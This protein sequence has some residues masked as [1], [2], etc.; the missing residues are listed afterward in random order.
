MDAPSPMPWWFR[1]WT[2]SAPRRAY[3]LWGLVLALVVFNVDRGPAVRLFT[4]GQT[5]DPWGRFFHAEL[6]RYGFQWLPGN[7]ASAP[8]SVWA[9]GI[10]LWLGTYLSGARL[11]NAGMSSRWALLFLVPG[12]RPLL[13]TILVVI[14]PRGDAAA[15]ESDSTPSS[16]GSRQAWLHRWMPSSHWG[17]ALSCSTAAAE[18]GVALVQVNTELLGIYGWTL[19]LATPYLLGFLA[20]WM[21]SLHRPLRKGDAVQI[22]F[23]TVISSGVLL[24]GLAIEG[25]ICLVMAAPIAVGLSWLGAATAAALMTRIRRR[26]E[27]RVMCVAVAIIPML[28]LIERGRPAPPPVYSFSSE[29]FIAA[30]ARRIWPRI[31][32]VAGLPPD[33]NFW[34]R[35]NLATFR[36]ARTE[37][38]GLGAV[39]VCEFDTGTARE[40]VTDW[41]PPFLLGLRVET[42][43]TP[44]QEWTFY[45]H[46]HPRHLE[47]YYQ[48]N[49]AAFELTPVEGGTLV[50]GTTEFQHGLWPADYW[51]WWCRP[52]IHGL[53]RRVLN[54]VKDRTE[55]AMG[56]GPQS[57]VP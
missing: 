7:D 41:E 17:C 28:C 57:R 30:P 23:L 40:I 53:Q 44:L 11:R 4:L 15:E 32:D 18:L 55:A 38:H 45:R 33:Q 25:V 43:P 51:A 26:S 9:G 2:W 19:F 47:G 34:S 52:V 8:A 42:T 27:G 16:A 31:V 35:L 29:V 20:T 49:R 10:A 39:R 54:A 22:S 5:D 56:T 12:I 24:F 3:L 14:P 36:R 6:Y 48:V 21:Y 50:R 13:G 37:G 46:I 1:L